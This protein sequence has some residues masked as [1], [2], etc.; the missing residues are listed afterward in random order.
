MTQGDA[1]DYCTGMGFDVD[2]P[3]PK[4]YSEICRFHQKAE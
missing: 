1:K 4:E 3:T 2:L